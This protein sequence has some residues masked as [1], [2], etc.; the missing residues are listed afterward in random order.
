MGNG[1]TGAGLRLQKQGSREGA[2]NDSPGRLRGFASSRERFRQYVS[3]YQ[4]R[5]SK[6]SLTIRHW[7]FSWR[8]CNS[9]G[10]WSLI[11]FDL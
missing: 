1:L 8:S 6:R 3:Q 2:K 5:G 10:T 9:L 4:D 11:V 7:P